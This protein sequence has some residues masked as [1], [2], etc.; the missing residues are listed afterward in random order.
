MYSAGVTRP[1]RARHYL[2]GDFGEESVPHSHPYR[3]E[4][5][6]S[7]AELDEHGFST[8]IAAMEQ[9]LETTLAEIDDVL[10]NDLPWFTGKQTSLE[11]LARYLVERLRSGL[12][13]RGA[14]PREPLQI[15]IW[16][17]D[18]AWAGYR[19]TR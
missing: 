13:Q 9:V 19:E 16:E 12:E 1:L 11:N 6:C 7:S 4:L 17:N 8:D 18:N 14:A 15:K 3:I 5:V 2:A 10:L